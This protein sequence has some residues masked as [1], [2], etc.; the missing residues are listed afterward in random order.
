MEKERLS[1]VGSLEFKNSQMGSFSEFELRRFL[2]AQ[3]TYNNV[4]YAVTI[5][6]ISRLSNDF[7]SVY[8]L[9]KL[10]ER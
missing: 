9:L 8:L 1:F 2:T 10:V 5:R 6:F 7:K 3:A 4:S